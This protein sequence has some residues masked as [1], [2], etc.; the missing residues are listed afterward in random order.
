[1]SASEPRPT[2]TLRAEHARLRRD[3]AHLPGVAADLAEWTA[4]DTPD[5]LQQVHGFLSAH[6]LPHAAS[7][8]AV[9]YPLLD[10]VM[11]ADRSTATMVADH[12][13][14][15]DR[16]D[17]LVALITAV[18]QGPPSPAEAEALREH[19]YGLWAIVRLHL[20]KEEEILFSLLDERLSPAD[21]QTLER[22]LAEFS[23]H[24]PG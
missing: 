20:D 10:K 14:I 24:A 9:L 12:A 11:G 13:E 6:L 7:E 5:Q 18:G 21:A 15:H 2:E 23:G 4:P 17:A 1:M 8:E 3:A 16:S 22:K 19:L